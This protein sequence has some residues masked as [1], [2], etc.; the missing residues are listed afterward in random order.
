VVKA[1]GGRKKTEE[2]SVLEGSCDKLGEDS[3]HSGRS[4]AMRRIRRAESD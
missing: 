2:L 3:C 4:D 1:G